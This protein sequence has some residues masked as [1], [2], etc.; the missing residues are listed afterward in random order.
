VDL[1][2]SAAAAVFSNRNEMYAYAHHYFTHFAPSEVKQ[3]RAYFRKEQRGFGEDAFHAMWWLLLREFR[4]RRCLEIGVYR[5]QVISL[6]AVIARKLGFPCEVH[7]ISPF[8]SMGDGVSVYDDGINYLEDTLASFRT[9][10]L[11][12]PT[13]VVAESKDDGAARHISSRP[14]DLIY[15]DGNHD[16]ETALSDYKLSRDNRRHGGLLVMDDSSLGTSFTPPRF[17]FSG[18]P[19]PSRVVEELANTE[20]I[21][22]GSVGHNNVFQKQ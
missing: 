3:H 7:G 10:G 21:P 19:G 4:P 17:A 13:L 12:A 18:H 2:F 8:S 15:I 1:S 5:G 6:W 9:F 14:W 11:D 16:Y 22:L 20:L